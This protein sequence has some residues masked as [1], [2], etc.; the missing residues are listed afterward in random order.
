MNTFIVGYDLVRKGSHDYSNLI[1]TLEN[2]FSKWWHH[3]DSTWV[4]VTDKTAK[5]VRDTL[6]PHMHQDDELLV[7]QSGGVGAW[8]GF[9]QAGSSWLLN[10]L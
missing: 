5:Q 4:I 8:A 2:S 7:I 3:L 1:A 10:N 6:R 9:N